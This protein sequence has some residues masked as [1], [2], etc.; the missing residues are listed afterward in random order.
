ME[1]KNKIVLFDGVCNLCNG[2]AKF[3]LKKDNKRQFQFISLQSEVGRELA[4]GNN[5]QGDLDSVILIIR[6]NVYTESDAA[7]EILKLLPA[8]WKWI[9]VFMIIPL[10]QRNGIY[11]WV[12]RNRYKWFGKSEVCSIVSRG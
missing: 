1:N 7:I 12:A 9:A 11:R 2:F 3:I 5:I 8:P 6:N 10:K 4:S